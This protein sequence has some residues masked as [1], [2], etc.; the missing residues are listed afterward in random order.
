MG[1]KQ[2]TVAAAMHTYGCTLPTSSAKNP[3]QAAG[4][5]DNGVG[6]YGEVFAA[7]VRDSVWWPA[8]AAH[9][10]VA[11]KCSHVTPAVR[12]QPKAGHSGDASAGD[13]AGASDLVLKRVAVNVFGED[14]GHDFVMMAQLEILAMHILT[15]EQHRHAD[16]PDHVRRG[17]MCCHAWPHQLCGCTRVA[18]R[19]CGRPAALV[20][21]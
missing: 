6:G 11:P 14:A 4:R 2:S 5:L 16:V 21:R 3:Y 1:H 20:Q 9:K 18:L 15:Q 10:S 7:R 13:E 12:G 19:R 17:A 8:C